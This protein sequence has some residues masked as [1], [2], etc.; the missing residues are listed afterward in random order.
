MGRSK[1]KR[2]SPKATGLEL[3][4][5]SPTGNWLDPLYPRLHRKPDGSVCEGVGWDTEI[6]VNER[7]RE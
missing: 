5:P 6:T 4:K 3:L 1:T 7:K 2:D